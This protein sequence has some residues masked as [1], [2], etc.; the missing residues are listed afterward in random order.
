MNWTRIRDDKFQVHF[1]VLTLT[2]STVEGLPEYPESL[3]IKDETGTFSELAGDYERQG[4]SHVWKYGEFEFAFI[5][6]Y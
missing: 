5:G 2:I 3:T 6:K 4:D 1:C